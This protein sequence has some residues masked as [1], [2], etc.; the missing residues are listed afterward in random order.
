MPCAAEADEAERP[1]EVAVQ[2]GKVTRATLRACV[3]AYGTVEAEPAGGG[4][5]AGSARLS[6]PAAG[7]VMAVPVKEGGRVE[8][9]SVMVELDDRVAL[10]QVE[11]A[12]NAVEFAEQQVARQNKLKAVEGTSES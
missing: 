3:N 6:A 8:A 2:V 1:T 10:A 11:K 9:G 7:I 12:R 5:P 4:K